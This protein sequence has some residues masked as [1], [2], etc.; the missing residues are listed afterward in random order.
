MI[1]LSRLGHIVLRVADLEKSKNFYTKH[2]DFTVL[3]AE[4]RMVVLGAGR[5]GNALDLI[6]SQDATASLP[7]RELQ[8][9]KGLGFHHA[10]FPVDSHE[11]LKGAYFS[12][13]DNGVPILAALDHGSTESFYFHDPDGNIIEI[14]WERPDGWKKRTSGQLKDTDDTLTF[15][16]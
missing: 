8:S 7:H 14:Y 9:L 5:L 6:Q 2:F 4:G 11:E 1:Q 13:K 15:T 16:R 3:E 12:L 10:G